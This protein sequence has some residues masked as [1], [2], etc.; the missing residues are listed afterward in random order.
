MKHTVKNEGKTVLLT[1]AAGGMGY[2]AVKRLAGEG[3]PVFA[4]DIREPEPIPGLTF[5]KTDLT[6]EASVLAAAARIEESGAKLDCIINMAG[7]YDLDSLVEMDEQ[8]LLRIFNVNLFS[9]FRV[10]KAFLPLLAEKG[11]IIITSSELAPLDPLPFTGV[12]AVTKA[13]VEKYAYSLRMELQLLGYSVILIRPGAVKTGLLD[14]S[15]KRLDDFCA[16]TKLYSCNAERFRRIVDSVEARNIPPEAI[17]ALTSRILRAK[18][19]KYVY[20]INR[21]PLLLIFN[22]L[23]DRLQTALIRSILKNSDD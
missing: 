14:V 7:M 23:P 13:A 2:A 21:N 20:K 15:T 8:A 10:N 5:I 4:L 9:V 3:C 11:R 1:G 19:P 18:R 16:N 12:Y 6:D 17:A 22:A